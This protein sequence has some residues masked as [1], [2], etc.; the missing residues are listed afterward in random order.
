MLNEDLLELDERVC[1]EYFPV[2]RLA[3]EAILDQK[4]ARAEM[5][6]KAKETR[7]QLAR[8][9]EKLRH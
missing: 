3:V 9:H 6:A 2:L 5:A 1:L 4:A 8:L 7:H